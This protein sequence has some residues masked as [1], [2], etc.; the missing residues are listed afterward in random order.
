MATKAA[1]LKEREFIKECIKLYRSL[2]SL[3]NV[4]SKVYYD[5]QRKKKAYAVLL[6]KYRE[7]F[8]EA[9]REDVKKKFNVLRTN[10]RKEFKKYLSAMAAGE[11]YSPSLWYFNE[12]D[13]LYDDESSEDFCESSILDAQSFTID[14]EELTDIEESSAKKV[15]KLKTEEPAD[16][17][18]P[19]IIEIRDEFYHWAMACASDLRKMERTQQLYAKKAFAD[20]I[21]EGQLGLLHRHSV[22]INESS[23]QVPQPL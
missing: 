22:K 13:F 12:L 15:K 19:N 8:P 10:Y 14:Y 23:S 18:Y 9:T 16:Q 11:S 4:K 6:T 20:I 17:E 3:W 7:M 5:R 1:K 21:L 2:P